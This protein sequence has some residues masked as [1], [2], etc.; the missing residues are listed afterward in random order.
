MRSEGTEAATIRD[1]RCQSLRRQTIERT[2]NDRFSIHRPEEIRV[3]FH[4]GDELRQSFTVQTCSSC[5]P[6]LRQGLPPSEKERS[7]H[8]PSGTN[9]DQPVARIA[10]RHFVG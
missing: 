7:C 9:A 4:C 3:L 1:G 6:Q 8:C 5:K 2:L 10:A